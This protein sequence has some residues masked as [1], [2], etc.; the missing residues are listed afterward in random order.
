MARWAKTYDAEVLAAALRRAFAA[1]RQITEKR[2]FGGLCFLLR[3]NMLCG[4]GG[5]GYMFRVGKAQH[6]K[7]LKKKGAS[8]MKINGRSFD[9]FIWVDP[10]ACAGPALKSWIALAEDYVGKLPP[11]EKK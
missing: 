10:A 3:G 7:A 1:R 2:M 6:D 4:T 5:P 8:E 11:K 9:G